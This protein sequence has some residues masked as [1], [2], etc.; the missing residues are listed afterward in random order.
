[1]TKLSLL[2]LKRTC[3]VRPLTTTILSFQL[4]KQLFIKHQTYNNRILITK[5][6]FKRYNSVLYNAKST[7]AMKRKVFENWIVLVWIVFLRGNLK[8]LEMGK[9]GGGREEWHW[10]TS[11][12]F[13]WKAGHPA[14]SAMECSKKVALTTR[15]K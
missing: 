2:T 9:A 10:W 1:M 11:Q 3:F 12:L 8:W 14:T 13:Q 4:Y 6:H 5:D 7:Y 15:N